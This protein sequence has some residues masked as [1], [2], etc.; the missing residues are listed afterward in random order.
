MNF[1]YRIITQDSEDFEIFSRIEFQS[2]KENNLLKLKE[3]TEEE[4][5]NEHKEELLKFVSSKT[6]NKI[7]LAETE[8][9]ETAGIVWVANRGGSE[10]WNQEIEPSWIYDIKVFTK[11]RRKGLGRELLKFAEKWS[12]NEFFEKIGL[13]VYGSNTNAINLYNSSGYITLNSNLQKNSCEAN[14][15][16]YDLLDYNIRRID[17]KNDSERKKVTSLGYDNL[18][19]LTLASI[20]KNTIDEE[21]L[22][23]KYFHLINRIDF[24]KEKHYMYVLESKNNEFIGF[25]WY[26][27]SKGDLGDK[28]YFWV[29]DF[30]IIPSYQDKNL[31]L[32]LLGFVEDKLFDLKLENIRLEMHLSKKRI[33]NLL[34]SNGYF[35]TNLYMRKLL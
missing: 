30:E 25:V 17:M 26:Y 10:L 18:K 32:A 8:S 12:R 28:N 31:E 3:K 1:N 22:K 23:E 13:H 4:L 29:M 19:S 34:K 16:Q 9:G 24:S 2:M 5:F 35:D 20:D 7:F 15:I 6:K 33:Y 27:I 11:F 21:I 14:K